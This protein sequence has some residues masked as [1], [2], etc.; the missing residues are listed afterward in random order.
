[1][2]RLRSG[3]LGRCCVA[4]VTAILLAAHVSAQ[5]VTGTISEANAPLDWASSARRYDSVANAS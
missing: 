2:F 1:M 3:A 4:L 5:T